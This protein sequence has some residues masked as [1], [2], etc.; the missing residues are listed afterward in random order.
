MD[1]SGGTIMHPQAVDAPRSSSKHHHELEHLDA[2]KMIDL[3]TC[4]VQQQV[5]PPWQH[6]GGH[7][8]GGMDGQERDGSYILND[9]CKLL[10]GGPFSRSAKTNI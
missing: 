4:V 9:R 2:R 6:A 10:L 5:I 1:G 8:T 7:P 3:T